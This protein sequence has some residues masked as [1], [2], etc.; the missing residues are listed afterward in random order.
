[1]AKERRSLKKSLIGFEVELFTINKNGYIVDAA[2]KLLKCA[3]GD[4]NL[5]IKKEC[6]SNMIEIASYPSENISNT[7]DYLLR[8]LEYL[9]SIAEKEDILLYPLGTYPG[10]FNPSMRDDRAYKIKESIFGKNRWKIAG[11][12]IGFHCHYDLPRG[13]FDSE[14]RILKMFVRSKIKDSLVNSYNFLIAADPALATFMQSSPFYQGKYFGKDS[15]VIMYRGG[16]VLNNKNGLYA[17]FEEFGG[18]PH[19]KLTALDIIDIITTR[20]ETWKS[21]IKK[22]GL[23]I[24]V[25]SLYGSILDTTWGPLK[26]NPHGTLEVRGMDINHPIY[27]TGIGTIIK[28]IMKKLQ[29]EFYAVVPSEIGIKEPFKVEGDVIYIPPY[30]Y[31]R[32][33]L[34]KLSA[35]KGLEND[36][37]FNY[38]KRFL[39]FAQSTMP[40]GHLKL[41][42]P[43]GEML[44][45]RKTVSDEILDFA[46]KKGFKKKGT[47]TNKLAAEITLNHSERLLREIVS[48]RK[49]IENLI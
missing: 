35:Y 24:K 3:K 26:I 14:L 1:M 29:E 7:M 43:F 40:K 15:R 20:Y 34:Q 2:D 28:Y 45:K 4:K 5:T 11:R 36:A 8:E 33:E 6:A 31:V 23:N 18:L 39:R 44:S 22:L 21:Y 27:I 47:I 38:C 49:M 9:V 25:L 42:K 17:N 13:I 32:N 19:Y 30:P 16:E 10:K 37:I 41:T 48:T 12:C 46:K